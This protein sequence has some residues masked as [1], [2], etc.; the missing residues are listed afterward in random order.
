MIKKNTYLLTLLS[1]FALTFVC[2]V[3]YAEEIDGGK[4]LR[5]GYQSTMHLVAFTTALDKGF[6]V[7][8]LAH[9]FN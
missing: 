2:T 9:Y 4:A 8:E 5:V 7:D 6:Y 1:V 3:G